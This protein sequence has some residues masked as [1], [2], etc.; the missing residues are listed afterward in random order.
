MNSQSKRP[1]AKPIR[2]TLALAKAN[3][4]PVARG[5]KNRSA[6]QRSGVSD[7]A[8]DII[9]GNNNL[10][11][12][13]V[14]HGDAVRDKKTLNRQITCYLRWVEEAY[15]ELRMSGIRRRPNP[16]VQV[17]IVG[18]YLRLHALPARDGARAG[19]DG[20]LVAEAGVGQ[21]PKPIR[22]D[23]MLES[24][25]RIV[26]IGGPG[27]GKSTLFMRFAWE[28]ARAHLE[29]KPRTP[30]LELPAP[31]PLPIF[32]PRVGYNDY[33][34]NVKKRDGHGLA[35]LSLKAYLS[36]YLAG[37]KG[38]FAL[39]GDFFDRLMSGGQAIILLFDGLDEVAVDAEHHPARAE[40]EKLIVG[41]PDAHIVATCRPAG[42]DEDSQLACDFKEVRVL[43]LDTSHVRKQALKYY[44]YVERGNSK[45]AQ[46]LTG[47]L[48]ERIER[49]ERLRRER[50][51]QAPPLIDSPLIV[52]MILIVHVADRK[53]PEQRAGFF[54]RVTETI[55]HSDHQ[56]VQEVQQL[57]RQQI[58]GNR[59]TDYEML[60]FVAYHM[61]ARGEG[62]GRDIDGDE[63]LAIFAGTRYAAYALALQVHAAHRGGL[64]EKGG[65][66]CR[67][68]H[69][70]LQ[71]FLTS[72][73]LSTVTL[74][75]GGSRRPRV[76]SSLRNWPRAGGARW[77]C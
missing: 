45:S 9:T 75:E 74:G 55:V 72:R 25:K 38:N 12:E 48:M 13:Y 67:F 37:M 53:M 15:R 11:V 77:R 27:S 59:L 76:S 21:E 54:K 30:L 3:D 57:L 2:R 56:Q 26:V 33:R 35:D 63:L 47:A 4:S 40:I 6:K 16:V 44:G 14:E 17:P 28:L 52:R 69:L 58:S 36:E 19:K 64:H 18:I 62:A 71:E 7:K 23:D 73:Y 5:K 50:D 29:G 42:Y 41:K 60:Q 61:H 24:G 22:L 70:S 8:R 20:H 66:Y 51:K 39:P 46:K 68:T 34:R 65:G 31:L 10:V 1:G 43:A 49:L 32:A